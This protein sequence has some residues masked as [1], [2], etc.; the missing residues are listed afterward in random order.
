MNYRRQLV[1]GV[2]DRIKQ[3]PDTIQGQVDDLGVQGHHPVKD[4]I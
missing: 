2:S 3:P 1:L 4:H